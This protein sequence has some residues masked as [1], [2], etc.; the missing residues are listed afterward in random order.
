MVI[1]GFT[2][3]VGYVRANDNYAIQEEW[4]DSMALAVTIAT[5]P[6]SALLFGYEGNFD[7][8]SLVPDVAVLLTQDRIALDPTAINPNVLDVTAAEIDGGLIVYRR[9]TI[10]TPNLLLAP[11]ATIINAGTLQVGIR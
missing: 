7:T 10:L 11:D 4:P 5:K 9:S 3:H 8:F 6:N 1:D 2:V